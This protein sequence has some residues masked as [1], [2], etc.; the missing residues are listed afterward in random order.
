MTEDT[1][2]AL[3]TAA[4][5]QIVSGVVN[6]LFMPAMVWLGWSLFASICS[7]VTCGAGSILY[8]CG[9]ASCLLTP[10]GIGEMIAGGLTLANPKQGAPIMKIMSMVEIVSVLFGGL[11]SCIAGVVVFRMLADPEVTTYLEG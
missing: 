8:F 9:F 3:K 1:P 11:G 6:F 2:Q 7:A 4:I 5:I 10:L